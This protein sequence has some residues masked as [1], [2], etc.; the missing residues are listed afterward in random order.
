[1]LPGWWTWERTYPIWRVGPAM[2]SRVLAISAAVLAV[3]GACLAASCGGNA[4]DDTGRGR[5]EGSGGA[6]SDAGKTETSVRVRADARAK[7]DARAPTGR[8]ASVG[9]ARA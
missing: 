8:D 3:L 4:L 9:A 6:A 2:R 7:L 1:M 5:N